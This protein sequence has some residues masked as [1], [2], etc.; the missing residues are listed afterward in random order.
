M[1]RSLYSEEY[2][3]SGCTTQFDDA[4][5]LDNTMWT[6]VSSYAIALMA[7]MS[8]VLICFA[9]KKQSLLMSLY[10]LLTGFGYVTVGA[11]S[12]FSVTKSDWQYRVLYPIALVLTLSG[13]ACLMRTGLLYYFFSGSLFANIIWI[14][15]NITML[16]LSLVFKSYIIGSIWMTVVYAGMSFVYFRQ[17]TAELKVG[18]EWM[19]LKIVAMFATVF[20]FLIQYTLEKS[21]G[22]SAYEN[23]FAACPLA[24]PTAFNNTAIKNVL[25]AVGVLFLAIAEIFLPTH[26]FWETEF[27]EDEGYSYEDK[28]MYEGSGEPSSDIEN[29]FSHE[30]SVDP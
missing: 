2:L 16:V 12:Q 17:A 5:A 6:Y 19:L 4:Y 21:C 29:A 8:G 15:T 11:S 25:V 28:N 1:T 13:T 20:G 26:D 22:V 14:S 10:F 7:L 23:C 3:T 9:D 24:D 30:D 18:R 27:D